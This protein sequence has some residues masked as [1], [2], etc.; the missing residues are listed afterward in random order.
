MQLQR[1]V[2]LT[3]ALYKVFLVLNLEELCYFLVDALLL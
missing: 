3:C 1:S 2:K